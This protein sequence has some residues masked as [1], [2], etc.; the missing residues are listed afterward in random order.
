MIPLAPRGPRHSQAAPNEPR[1]L[2]FVAEDAIWAEADVFTHDPADDRFRQPP[3]GKPREL[4][5]VHE[6]TFWNTF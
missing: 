3:Q 5:Y 2:T 4:S 1:E 6:G